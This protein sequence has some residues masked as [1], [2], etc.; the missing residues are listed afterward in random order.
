MSLGLLV[1]KVFVELLLLALADLLP[2]FRGLS[3]K[4]TTDLGE[5]PFAGHVCLRVCHEAQRGGVKG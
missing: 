4:S 2:L 3:P 5:Q 1:P